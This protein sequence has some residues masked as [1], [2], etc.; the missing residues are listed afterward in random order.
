MLRV[1]QGRTLGLPVYT[2]EDP[3]TAPTETPQT[4]VIC[5]AT[6]ISGSS[7]PARFAMSG[8]SA[9]A[10][11]PSGHPASRDPAATLKYSD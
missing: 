10:A 3:R 1:D 7:P 6:L 9:D 2:P 4:K 11:G 8:A 5:M